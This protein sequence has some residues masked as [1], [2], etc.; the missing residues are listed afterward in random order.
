M[1]PHSDIQR[2]DAA[3]GHIPWHQAG[4]PS[5]V[6]ERVLLQVQPTVLRGTAI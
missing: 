6:S 5:G 1:G 4:I 3:C 2:Q